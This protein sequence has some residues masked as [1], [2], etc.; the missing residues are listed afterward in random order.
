MTELLDSRELGFDLRQHLGRQLVGRVI[1]ELPEAHLLEGVVVLMRGELGNIGIEHGLACR[2]GHDGFH[3]G[4]E[5]EPR[6]RGSR[7]VGPVT[8]MT[9]LAGG[10]VLRECGRGGSGRNGGGE[11]QFHLGKASESE[12]AALRGEQMNAA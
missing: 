2:I 12:F 7:G 9:G 5:I 3:R 11:K 8:G 1:G 6:G 10:R 4:V